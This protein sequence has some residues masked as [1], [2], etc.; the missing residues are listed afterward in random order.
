MATNLLSPAAK[1]FQFPSVGRSKDAQ[2]PP[3]DEY[4]P[5]CPEVGFRRNF[6]LSA[7][8]VS[9]MLK[10]NIE[11]VLSFDMDVTVIVMSC[12]TMV[13]PTS[14][15]SIVM[16]SPTAYPAPPLVMVAEYV[17]PFLTTVNSA[18][19]GSTSTVVPV[20]AVPVTAVYVLE[21]SPNTAAPQAPASVSEWVD[22]L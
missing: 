9:S 12:S 21:V 15:P 18:G 17:L 6:P 16:V 20:P 3:S 5:K 1:H 4:L 11:L 13:P 10:V 19:I 14:L 2:D 22:T 8:F 7:I